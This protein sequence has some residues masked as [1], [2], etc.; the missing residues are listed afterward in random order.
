M[1]SLRSLALVAAC[2]C[3]ALPAEARET[4]HDLSVEDAK[5]ST[6]GQ[7]KL[8]D[9]PIYMKGQKHPKVAKDLGVFTSN[10]RTNAFNKSDEQACEVAF[11]SAL[12]A[13]QKRARAEGGDAVVD[14]RSI[15]KHNDLE[16]ATQ[17][18]CVAG[19]VIA[20]VALEGR[21]VRLGK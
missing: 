1:R 8:L 6:L 13:L 20:N 11:L 19:A 15:T 21:V 14:V 18:R 10:R 9:L 7:E 17:F 5:Q 16:S 3:A 4:F 12:I 2:L